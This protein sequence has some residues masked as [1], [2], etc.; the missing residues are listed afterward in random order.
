MN[1]KKILYSFLSVVL[2]TITVFSFVL[3]AAAQKA[4][5]LTLG[6]STVGGTYFVLGGG[7][8][9]IIGEKLDGVQISIQEGGGPA[10]NIQLIE[11]DTAELGFATTNVAYQGWN[12]LE[13]ANGVKYHKMR[14]IFPMYASYLHVWTLDKPTNP[15]YN[16]RDLEGKHVSTG[17]PGNTSEI[18][19][20]AA[21]AVLGITPSNLSML[22][23]S[24]QISS[25]KDGIID[26]AITV[27]GLPGPFML[28]L[29]STHDPRLVWFSGEDLEKIKEEYPTFFK[30]IIPK[31]TYKNQKEDITTISF[32]N[33][34]IAH[35]DLP[36]DLVYNI[37]KTTFENKD[38]WVIAEPSIR[39]LDP[40]NLEYCVPIPLH[41]GAV[42]YYQE[43]GVKIPEALLPNF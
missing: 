35:K 36:D 29:E 17:T 28:E 34:V 14:S 7:W 2:I 15:I 31:G 8:A 19:G 37:V 13:W 39:Q 32:W 24:T 23:T 6:T 43:I 5:R 20:K 38:E 41:P 27:T 1:K 16:F 3:N 11:G 30:G 4:T 12:G 42:K 21:M 33:I 26:V 18:A 40:N 10:T 9:K 25:I 22:A